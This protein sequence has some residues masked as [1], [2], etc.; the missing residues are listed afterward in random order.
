MVGIS[1]RKCNKAFT[2]NKK[3]VVRLITTAFLLPFRAFIGQL[4]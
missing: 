3:A 4:L 2:S 1:D